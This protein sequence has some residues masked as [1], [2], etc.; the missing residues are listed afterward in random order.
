MPSS[1]PVFL[2]H[3]SNDKE[4]VAAIEQALTKRGIVTWLD[5]KNLT[6]GKPLVGEVERALLQCGSAAIFLGSTGPSF[7]QQLE[8]DAI[9]N[10]PSMHGKPTIPVFLPGVEPDPKK[11]S[12]L[13][14]FIP[15]LL[16]SVEEGNPK[17]EQAIDKLAEGVSAAAQPGT[18]LPKLDVARFN[19]YRSLQPFDVKDASVFAGRDAEIQTSLNVLAER[20]NTRF[21]M[22]VGP[23]GSG[24]SSLARAG[25]LARYIEQHK[26]AR[27]A[28]VTPGNRPLE[29][30]ALQ[31]IRAAGQEPSGDAIADTSK[32]YLEDQHKLRRDALALN[33]GQSFVLL[34]DQSEQAFSAHVDE[35]ERQAFFDNIV[36]TAGEARGNTSVIMT[37]RSDFLDDCA[38]YSLKNLVTRMVLVGPMDEENLRKAIED[39]ARKA[40]LTV[41]SALTRQLLEDWSNDESSLPLLQF[42]LWKLWQTE[43]ATGTLTLAGYSK[44]GK[45]ALN[46]HAN[47]VYNGF[48]TDGIPNGLQSD[49][50]RVIADRVF[51]RLVQPYGQSR[52]TKQS[53]PLHELLPAEATR[54]DITATEDVVAILAGSDCRLLTVWP[55]A[56]SEAAHDAIVDLSHEVLLSC[57]TR[58]ETLLNDN[59]RFLLWKERLR[60]GLTDYRQHKGKGGTYLEGPL[61]QEAEQ[62]LKQ[63]RKEH[64]PDEIA[65]IEASRRHRRLTLWLYAAVATLVVGSAVALAWANRLK[66][67]S[68]RETL[69]TTTQRLIIGE[70]PC[71]PAAAQRATERYPGPDTTAMLLEAV[72]ARSKPVL[73]IPENIADLRFFHR[74]DRLLVGIRGETPEIRLCDS[75]LSGSCETVSTNGLPIARLALSPN[76]ELMIAGGTNGGLMAWKLGNSPGSY[77]TKGQGQIT[78]LAAEKDFAL[79]AIKD[80]DKSRLYRWEP[81]ENKLEVIVELPA[82][83][84]DLA[85][86]P[87]K[88]AAVAAGTDQQLHFIS[89]QS[90]TVTSTPT[91]RVLRSVAFTTDGNRVFTVDRLGSA[92]I[93]D[94]T[95]SPKR[96]VQFEP[97]TLVTMGGIDSSGSRW[98]VLSGNRKL[99]TLWSPNNRKEEYS[100]PVHEDDISHLAVSADGQKVALAVRGE[101]IRIHDLDLT[102]LRAR[103]MSTLRLPKDELGPCARYLSPSQMA[104]LLAPEKK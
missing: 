86:R 83:I 44:F 4:S 2:C 13:L 60:I 63:K 59:R 72:Q 66:G 69:L 40:G 37:L 99:L 10:T 5:V 26:T 91:G 104:E 94:L 6:P 48:A 87:D 50:Q 54:E 89:L 45:S 78:A 12:L 22:L 3:N 79:V 82:E 42:V 61:L 34:M 9:L 33:G 18:A 23:S 46:D 35:K 7:W 84:P 49:A 25:V 58:L 81:F 88:S 41:E 102:R 70:H 1:L 71:A 28:I 51:L 95:G 80:T 100:I 11:P 16:S 73:H 92:S 93:W 43:G 67:Q 55:S 64:S 20:D 85:I 77:T 56:T 19:P 62:W 30:L 21:L 17:F 53:K 90:R 98:I 39:P 52:F 47:A 31:M 65:F 24:K 97:P 76:D 103:A 14:N 15:V 29:Q 57:W 74:S 96:A 75:G 101:G 36:N 38:R 8:I 27:Y 68:N 32:K